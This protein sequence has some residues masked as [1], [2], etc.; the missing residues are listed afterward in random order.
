MADG[1]ARNH[2]AD[3]Q[4]Y[5]SAS[6][7]RT[8]RGDTADAE[9]GSAPATRCGEQLKAPHRAQCKEKRLQFLGGVAFSAGQGRAAYA[10]FISVWGLALLAARFAPGFGPVA[11]GGT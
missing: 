11:L 6:A 5:F 3:C 8:V 7:R 4:C 2:R 1:T 9:C 10:M